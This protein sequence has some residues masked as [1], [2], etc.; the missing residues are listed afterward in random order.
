MFSDANGQVVFF[1][2]SGRA[3]AA[4][5]P[6]P[7][8]AADPVDALIARNRGRGVE[9]DWRSGLPAYGRDGHLAWEIAVAAHPALEV[10]KERGEPADAA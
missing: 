4:S 1:A 2:P 5:P 3:I 8:L 9:P 6:L 10:S 7:D